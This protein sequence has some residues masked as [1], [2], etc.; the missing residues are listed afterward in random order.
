MNVGV[1]TGKYFIAI[2]FALLLASG[3]HAMAVVAPPE[4]AFPVP[5]DS[6]QDQQIHSLPAK[7]LNRIQRQ[8]FNLV[9]AV[10]FVCSIVHTF[11]VA[12]FRTI[13]HRLQ[14]QYEDLEPLETGQ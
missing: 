9:A 5:I 14:H 6:Y 12:K 1:A 10:I 7:L 11:L 8:P 3:G 2:C 13:A 4:V